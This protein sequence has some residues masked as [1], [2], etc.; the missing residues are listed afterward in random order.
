MAKIADLVRDA[1]D[2]YSKAQ[3]T[4]DAIKRVR[5]ALQTVSDLSK[6]KGK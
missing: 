2:K 3:K 1:Q 5:E 6:L 4:H